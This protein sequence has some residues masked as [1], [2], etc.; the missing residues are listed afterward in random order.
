MKKLTTY[1]FIEK[2]NVIHNGVYD[3]GKTLYKTNDDKIVVTCNIHGDFSISAKNHLKGQGCKKCG[4][5][6]RKKNEI[7]T[8]NFIEKSNLI[9]KNIYDYSKTIYKTAKDKVKIIC[10]KHGVFEM[11]PNNHLSGQGCRMCSKELNNFQKKHW[12]EKG[13]NRKGIF[14][15]IKCSDE[16][17]S[18]CKF[19]ITFVSI[20]S[21]Y[22]GC[23]L[24]YNY[25]VIRTI[26]SNDLEYIWNLE[27]RFKKFVSKYKYTP[28]KKFN[29]HLTECYINNLKK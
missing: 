22:S 11:N 18:F 8:E 28:L 26:E 1:E 29:G 27:K 14:Y 5:I 21:R 6:N 15:I 19:G 17:E 24:P 9:H 23:R 2:S 3:Y 4:Y 10:K 16:Y 20:K 25:E 13:K 12:I 7:T